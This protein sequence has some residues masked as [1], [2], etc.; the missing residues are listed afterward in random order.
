L[1]L[2]VGGGYGLRQEE[3]NKFLKEVQETLL[4]IPQDSNVVQFFY[5]DI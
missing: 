2:D 3:Q 4:I 1:L 5:R